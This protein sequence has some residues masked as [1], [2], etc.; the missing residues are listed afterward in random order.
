MTGDAIIVNI[1]NKRHCETIPPAP[2]RLVD[3]RVDDSAVLETEARG[4]VLD[5]I[6]A[7]LRRYVP[8]GRLVSEELIRERRAEAARENDK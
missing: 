8:E 5:R 6:Q 2:R 7:R 4:Q 3:V 1:K